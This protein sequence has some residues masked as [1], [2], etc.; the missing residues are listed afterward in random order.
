M[1]ALL[2]EQHEAVVEGVR[3]AGREARLE[4][5]G[6]ALQQEKHEAAAEEVPDKGNEVQL[7]VAG[8]SPA[9]RWCAR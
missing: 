5:A 7:E 3:D 9:T 4:L 8:G 2:Q 6:A 1:A